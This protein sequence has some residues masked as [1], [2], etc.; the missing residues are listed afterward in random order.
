MHSGYVDYSDV[1]HVHTVQP[2]PP[3][4]D[5]DGHE[6]SQGAAHPISLQITITTDL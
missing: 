1:R 5:H 2:D 3:A 6:P 4:C